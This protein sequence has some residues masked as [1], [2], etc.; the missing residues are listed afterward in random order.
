MNTNFS[1]K[2]CTEPNSFELCRAVEKSTKL[3]SQITRIRELVEAHAGGGSKGGKDGS[4]DAD[5]RLNDELP[6]NF[7]GVVNWPSFDWLDR[8]VNHLGNYNIVV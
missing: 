2:V 1:F 4:E 5:E 7:L 6:E 3:I 8:L